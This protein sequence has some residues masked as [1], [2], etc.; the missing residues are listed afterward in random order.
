MILGLKEND[1]EQTSS[2]LKTGSGL[3]FRF[4]AGLLTSARTNW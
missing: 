3:L 2:T 1:L 4:L